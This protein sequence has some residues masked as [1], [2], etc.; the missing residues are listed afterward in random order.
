MCYFEAINCQSIHH[1][2]FRGTEFVVMK[3]WALLAGSAS[4][5]NGT[6]SNNYDIHFNATTPSSNETKLGDLP[7]V[8]GAK[9]CP[10]ASNFNDDPD[11]TK[12]FP[13]GYYLPD[14]PELA[15]SKDD[16][17]KVT[18]ISDFQW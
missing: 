18:S 16:Y 4:A 17:Q 13:K 1:S 9:L 15:T 5:I 3:R 7:P 10:P 6:V 12:I 8:P 2:H 14:Y 11:G